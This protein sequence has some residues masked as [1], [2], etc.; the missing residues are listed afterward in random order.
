MTSKQSDIARAQNTEGV[1][2]KT[3]I[4]GQALIEGVMMRGKYNWAV[5]IRQPDGTIYTEEHELSDTARKHRCLSWPIFRGCRALVESLILGFKALD[6]ATEKAY[7]EEE[8]EDDEFSYEFSP[9]VQVQTTICECAPDLPSSHVQ[10][11]S[12]KE[13][14]TEEDRSEESEGAMSGLMIASTIIG[15]V[16]AVVIFV[17][18]PA[19]LANLTVGEYDANPILWNVVDGVMR[20]A[21]FIVYIWLISRMKDIKRMFA[22]H[23]A[24]HKTIHCYEHGLQ[25]TPENA[26]QFPTLHVR[27]G[28]AFLIMTLFLAIIVFSLVPVKEISIAL[29]ITDGIGQFLIIVLSRI[30]LIPLIAGLSYELTVKWAGNHPENPLV[31]IVLWPGLQM[32]RLTTSEPDESMLEC[33]IAA[34]DL[35]LAREDEVQPVVNSTPFNSPQ[36]QRVQ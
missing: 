3:H 5:A 21:I 33:A 8:N 24:E 25:L 11:N 32:Q 28:T 2:C 22:Y 27:C 12:K 10:A 31:K 4:G 34:M 35:V 15:I 7:S 6:I 30:I 16:L 20:V 14:F 1:L 36:M 17:M 26:A 9:H 19:F 23:G 29:G 13:S 18:V